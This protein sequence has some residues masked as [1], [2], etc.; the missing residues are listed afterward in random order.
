MHPAYSVI[1]FTVASGAGFGL[2]I[3]LGLAPLA[4]APPEGGFAW[5]GFVL[6]FLLSVAGLLSSTQHLGHPERAWRAFTQWRSSWLSREGVL[7]VATLGLG[8]LYALTAL[9]GGGAS[10]LLGLLTA[11]GAAATVYATAMIYAQLRTVQRWRTPWTTACYLGFAL[12]S[13]GVLYALAEAGFAE[14]AGGGAPSVLLATVALA[15]AWGAKLVWWAEGDAAPPLSTPETATGLGPIGRVRLFEAPHTSENYLL[16]EM[17]YRIARK[18]AR[19]LRRLALGLGGLAP[20]VLTLA[21][22]ALPAPALWLTL[23]AL[24][25]L[26]GLLAERWL[27]FAEAEHAVMTYYARERM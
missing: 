4:G 7:A 11:A 17:G 24:A 14:R 8:G 16:K 22:A 20:A 25:H 27:F 21:A 15:A 13:G 5:A 10:T 23:A 26:A 3:W 2:F 18:H 9:F 6:A 12:A 19:K 1:F